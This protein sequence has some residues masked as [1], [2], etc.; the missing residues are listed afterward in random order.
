MNNEIQFQT[1]I[2]IYDSGEGMSDSATSISDT[3]MVYYLLYR[4]DEVTMK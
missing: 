4:F 2:Q 1:F 3:N